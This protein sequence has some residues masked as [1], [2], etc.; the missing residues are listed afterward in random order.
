MDYAASIAHALSGHF[1]L[2]VECRLRYD[3]GTSYEI[4][5]PIFERGRG[6]SLRIKRPFKRKIVGAPVFDMYGT[7]LISV[8]KAMD[9]DDLLDAFRYL[10][11]YEGKLSIDLR[12]NGVG[13]HEPRQ[14][15]RALQAMHTPSEFQMRISSVI[16]EGCEKDAVFTL[17]QGAYGFLLM[18][19]GVISDKAELDDGMPDVE[20]AV[21]QVSTTRYE[22]SAKNRAMCIAAHGTSCAVCGFDFERVY[23]PFAAGYIE[24]HHK[25]PVSQMDG[26]QK[27]DPV[28]DLVPLCPN[29]H[30]AVHLKNPPLM[31]EELKTIMD[32]GSEAKE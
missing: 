9:E 16:D 13:V 29:C 24:V 8:W 28:R 22:R 15:L 5:T 12:I 25:T 4:A 2:P 27:I 23:G 21:A 32:D 26:E 1:G 19:S 18:L 7:R 20:G 6:V 31:P 3:G 30:A 17:A 11:L 10:W 14:A